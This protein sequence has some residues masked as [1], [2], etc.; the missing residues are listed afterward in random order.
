MAK[1]KERKE[2]SPENDHCDF[3]WLLALDKHNF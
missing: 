1:L 3:D 2:E